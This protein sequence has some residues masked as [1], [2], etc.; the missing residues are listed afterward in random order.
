[1]NNPEPCKILIVDDEEMIRDLLT[2]VLE[3]EN[4]SVET[5]ETAKQAIEASK[6]TD[7][8][9]VLVEKNLPDLLGPA[10]IQKL[11]TEDLEPEFIIMAAYGSFDSVFN[12][13][14]L[15]VRA[16]ILKPFSNISEIKLKVARAA[17]HYQERVKLDTRLAQSKST[18][19]PAPPSTAETPD[20]L[21]KLSKIRADLNS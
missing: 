3:E 15:G 17:R 14:E 1:M 4:Y 21:L 8:G 13:I 18:T 20:I 10:L 2:S 11:K 19:K 12:A 7:F 16:Y 5:A 9:V 6:N